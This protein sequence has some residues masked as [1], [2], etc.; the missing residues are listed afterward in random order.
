MLAT[1]TERIREIG[2]RRA[3]EPG[4]RMLF[5]TVETVALTG[6]GGLLA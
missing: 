2:I 1:V 4:S 6:M 5:F 3:I